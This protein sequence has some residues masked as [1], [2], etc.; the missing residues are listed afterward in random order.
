MINHMLLHVPH[1]PFSAVNHETFAVNFV[2]KADLDLS[3][4]TAVL[5]AGPGRFIGLQSWFQLWTTTE[6]GLYGY[7]II[8]LH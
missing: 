3:E 1:H 8:Y 4:L 5:A 2:A 6:T 7:D